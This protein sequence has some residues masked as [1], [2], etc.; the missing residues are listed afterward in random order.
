MVPVVDVL[1]KSDDVGGGD[2]LVLL[3]MSEQRVCGWAV[4]TAF[5]S[6]E[7]D[8]NRTGVGMLDGRHSRLC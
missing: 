1:F 4:G 7:L 6:E 2:R 3:Q 8:Q 5:G